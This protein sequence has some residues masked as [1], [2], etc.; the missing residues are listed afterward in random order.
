MS[1]DVL[2]DFLLVVFFFF[3]L[4]LVFGFLF[5][6]FMTGVLKMSKLIFLQGFWSSKGIPINSSSACTQTGKLI[7]LNTNFLPPH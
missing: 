7:K 4:C 5:L 3:F 6:Y 2:K 1:K